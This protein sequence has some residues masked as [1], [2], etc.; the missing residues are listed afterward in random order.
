MADNG[1]DQT[2]GAGGPYYAFPVYMQC[3]S[4]FTHRAVGSTTKK[5][6]PPTASLLQTGSQPAGHPDK[7]D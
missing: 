1:S 6:K 7:H 3:Q 4:N 2:F 5:T